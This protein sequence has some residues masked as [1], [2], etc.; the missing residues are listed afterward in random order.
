MPNAIVPGT[1]YFVATPL[2]N[3]GDMTL[4][5]L[6][7][8]RGVD[9]I[10]AEDTRTTGLLLQALGLGKKRQVSHHQH[11]AAG[12]VPDLV[13]RARDEQL[14]IAVVSDAG[15]PGVS[16]PGSEL[17]AACWAAGVPL[18]PVPGACAA[19]AAVSVAGFPSTEFVF[20]GFL[21]A[22]GGKA[23]RAKVAE[24]AAQD[25][26]SVLYEAP[27]RVLRT[28]AELVEAAREVDGEEVGARRE[29]LCARELTKLHEELFRGTLSEAVARFEARPPRGEFTLVV[30]GRGGVGVGMLAG[31]SVEEREEAAKGLLRGL[32]AGGAEGGSLSASEAAKKVAK[33]V[34][35]SKGEVYKLALALK[36]E[37]DEG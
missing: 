12:R 5:A 25:K 21:P 35:L 20:Y 14:S 32:M 9:L 2:G 6:D 8:L 28:L 3:L 16:D 37:K 4:R 22:K 33:D 26:P 27:H 31:A 10:A 23:R 36:E 19:V 30:A 15:T 34:G 24:V 11:N 7:V 1:V 29:V 13:R 17:A 18:V